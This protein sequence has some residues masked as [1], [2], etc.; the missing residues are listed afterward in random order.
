MFLVTSKE[1]SCT[2]C[3]VPLKLHGQTELCFRLQVIGGRGQ[4][5]YLLY[6]LVDLASDLV[7]TEAESGFL[8]VVAL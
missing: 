2:F 4:E 7:Q 6:T 8:S 3:S 1:I 5:T